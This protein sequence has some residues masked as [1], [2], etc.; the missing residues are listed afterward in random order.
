[1]RMRMRRTSNGGREGMK[2]D[3]TRRSRIGLAPLPCAHIGIK[4]NVSG[5]RA[6]VIRTHAHVTSLSLCVCCVR[7]GT[8]ERNRISCAAVADDIMLKRRR[9]Y[10]RG[11]T[12]VV[13]TAAMLSTGQIDGGGRR[14]AARVSR[15]RRAERQQHPR[16][17]VGPHS[18]TRPFAFYS[19]RRASFRCV[20]RPTSCL[21]P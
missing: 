13:A 7:Y 21:A 9:R 16:R 14:R 1:M 3:R 8:V 12:S 4:E 10:T 18:V 20:S 5:A 11:S 6:R 15:R 17:A 19:S 2:N